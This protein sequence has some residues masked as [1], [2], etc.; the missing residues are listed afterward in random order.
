MIAHVALVLAVVLVAAKLA[1]E[2]ASR[3][4]Q[5]PVLGE[6]LAGIALGNLP[7]TLG[8]ALGTD[9]SL[10]LLAQLGV[11]L[12]LFQVGIESTVRDLLE[13]GADAARAAVLGTVGSFAVGFVCARL[14]LP[15]AGLVAHVFLGASITA[16]SVGIT[17]RVFKDLGRTRSLE[18]R[19]I[20]GAAV[21]DDVLGL[22]VLA[23]VTGWVASRGR[24]EATSLVSLA[25]LLAKTLALLVT[26]IAVGVRVTPRIFGAAARLRTPGVLLAIGLSFCFLFAWGAGAIGLAPLIGAF[27][28]GLVLEEAH[29]KRFVARG[30]KPLDELVEPIT[31]FLVPIFF[32]VMGARVEV[33]A[34]AHG[35]TLALAAALCLA[36]VLGKLA[37]GLG[38]RGTSKLAVAS[39]MM[40]RGE[41]TLIFASIGRQTNV[42]DGDAYSAVVLVVVLTTIFTPTA[43]KWS[44]ARAKPTSPEAARSP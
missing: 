18:A 34:F 15:G 19:T 4:K 13:V 23:L 37:C 30:E 33:A 16:T 28:A 43:L 17:A 35:R 29:S 3:L 21:L 36:A 2:G 24:G 31:Q 32:V 7:W 12:L 9:A 11:L 26:A 5:P 40:P 14:A 42:I 6:L 44:L 27:A 1:G 25:I 41:V 20:L 8:R 38:V 10:D 39:G 22:V